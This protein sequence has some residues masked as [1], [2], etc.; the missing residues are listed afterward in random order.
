MGL[1]DGWLRKGLFRLDPERAHHLGMAAIRSGWIRPPVPSDPRLRVTLW[2]TPFANPLGLAAGF[3]K[4]G[5]GA[6][7]WHHLGFGFAEL[8]T[9]TLEA[10][11]GNPTPRLFRL[12]QDRALINRMGFNNH[13]AGAMERTLEAARPGL[14]LGINLGKLKATS[15]ERAAQEYAE[16][17]RR[18]H[19]F[20][21][22]VVINVSS[23]NTPGL[24]GLQEK[25]PLTEI[26]HAVREVIGG[27]PLLAK[28]APDLTASQLDD[29]LDVAIDQRLE[30]LIATNTTLSRDGLALDP[31]EAGGLSGAPLAARADEVL[32]YLAQGLPPG[33]VL[34][35]SGGV[36]TGDDVVRKLRLGATLVQAY[37]GFVYGGP[38]WPGQVLR[39]VLEVLDAEGVPQVGDLCP[40]TVSSSARTGNLPA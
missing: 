40:R 9:V 20:G 33:A 32:A 28:I 12:P 11:P 19:R 30:G 2:G 23:P 6:S 25:G 36:M 18:L 4:D 29:V 7:Q 13:G 37:T 5:V 1:Y 8:G 26:L 15:P 10:Q 24:R 22:Y 31:G 3:D 39:R 16:V 17:A 35:A 14:P 38:A 21:A 34:I 27:R